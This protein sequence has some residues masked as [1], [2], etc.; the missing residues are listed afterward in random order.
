MKLLKLRLTSN[1]DVL[2][3][4]NNITAIKTYRSINSSVLG[5][6]VFT[7]DGVE[8]AVI[9][10]VSQIETMINGLLLSS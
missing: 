2:I 5:T 4:A 6:S 3:N 7:V 8:W 9:E 10:T 1:N